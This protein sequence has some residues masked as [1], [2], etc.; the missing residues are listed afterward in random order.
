MGVPGLQQELKH[1][2]SRTFRASVS[3]PSLLSADV[4]PSNHCDVYLGCRWIYPYAGRMVFNRR[5]YLL[6]PTTAGGLSSIER[7]YVSSLWCG[8]YNFACFVQCIAIVLPE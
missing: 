2:P 7:L 8:I 1:F 6:E 5:Q 3:S 4:S